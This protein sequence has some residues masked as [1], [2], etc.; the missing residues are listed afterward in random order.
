MS[1]TSQAPVSAPA[2]HRRLT[3]AA[4]VLETVLAALFGLLLARAVWFIAFG[5]SAAN[6]QFDDMAATGGQGR[7]VA[8]VADI[9]RLPSADLFASRSLAA[10]TPARIA[11]IPE[12]RL[13]LVVRGIRT[14]L[15]ADNGVAFLRTPDGQDK[16]FQPGDEIVD[17]V[18]LHSLEADRVVIDRRGT[19]E[20]LVLRE[21]QRP[22]GTA[23]QAGPVAGNRMADAGSSPSDLFRLEPVFEGRTLLGYRMAAQ[24]EIVLTALGLRR[25]DLL[26]AVDGQ[27]LAEADDIAEVFERLE[28]RE[29]VSLSIR[30]G[31]VPL[32]LQVDLS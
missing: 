10:P 8:F 14:G 28:G 12:S 15:T 30:R 32:T 27:V 20:A 6:F 7:A 23:A 17:G 11:A 16:R 22:A 21:P 31:G 25:D 5:A 26:L 3:L 24:S 2:F 13:D 29:T 19:L 18:R 9:D 4:R 1:G